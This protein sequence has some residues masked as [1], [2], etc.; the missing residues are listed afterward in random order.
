MMF[1]TSVLI[2]LLSRPR[3]SPL[4]KKLIELAGDEPLLASSIQFGELADIARRDGVPVDRIIRRLE[5]L[6]V[7]I[8]VDKDISLKASELKSTARQHPKGKKFS[9]IDGI[10]L[11]TARNYDQQLV[12]MNG[13]FTPF[14]D[15]IRLADS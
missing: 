7:Q 8:D 14:D 12:T 15:V 3:Q 4:V 5:P 1:D 13:D 10:I 6:L 9:L 11:A 2:E